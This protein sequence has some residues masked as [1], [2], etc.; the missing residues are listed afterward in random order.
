MIDGS[1]GGLGNLL[2]LMAHIVDECGLGDLGEGSML[3]F[4]PASEV[5]QIIGVGTQRTQ[6]ELPEALGIKEGIRP[7]QFSSVLVA[8]AI[9][10]SAGPHGRLID[11]RELHRDCAPWR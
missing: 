8:Q 5:E 1:G 11:H 10:G 7:V 6:G 3:R 9:G 2:E 4:E